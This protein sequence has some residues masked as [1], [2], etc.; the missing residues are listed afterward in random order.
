M[1]YSILIADDHGI[2]RSGIKALLKQYFETVKIDEAA[3][4]DEITNKVRSVSFDILILDIN[5]PG[6][7]FVGL[8]GWLKNTSPDT[9]V[10]IF[11]TYPE[12]IY[13]ER[14]LQ[15]GAKGFVN[16]TA[17]DLEI[18]KAIRQVMDGDLYVSISLQKTRSDDESITTNPFDKLSVRELEIALLI[19]HGHKLPEICTRLNIQY[20]TANTYKRRIFEKLQVHNAVSLSHLMETFNIKG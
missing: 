14:C 13:G 1:P 18:L 3:T 20:S 2:V 15:L 17:P 6:S 10:I 9:R 4:E 8:M 12:E 16:K 5:I 11:T 19:N 7:D